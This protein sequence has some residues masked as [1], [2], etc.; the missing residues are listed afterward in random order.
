M[1][2]SDRLFLSVKSVLTAGLPTVLCVTAITVATFTAGTIFHVSQAANRFVS[3]QLSR[4]GIG[5]VTLYSPE[6]IRDPDGA[7][8]CLAALDGADGIMPFS[9][10]SGVL[11]GRE[12][13]QN[14]VFMG[15][16]ADVTAVYQLEMLHGRG[17]TP[18]EL[19]AGEPV[20]LVD[21]QLAQTLYKRSN[22]LG[23]QLR[24]GADSGYIAATVIGV[25]RSQ[26]QGLESAFGIAIPEII[27]LPLNALDDFAGSIVLDKIAVTC[28]DGVDQD[29]FGEQAARELTRLTGARFKY[30]NISGYY[31]LITDV[32]A[33]TGRAILGI[34][35]VA[36]LVGGLGL[37]IAML[38]AVDRRRHTIGIYMALG[39][40]AGTVVGLFILEALELCLIGGTAGSLLSLAAMNLLQQML[41][42][43]VR[44]DVI[45]R[46]M[47]WSGISGVFFGILPAVRAARMDPIQAL[48]D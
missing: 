17:F 48:T 19:A 39:A 34:G 2:L 12:S 21:D 9:V 40:P 20:I 44:R 5:G 47:F 18:S 38:S 4:I 13:R 14:A 10:T 6:P 26:K 29:A 23:K 43:E 22:I 36:V 1:R 16:N 31:G 45:L 7:A 8:A 32:T 24:L 27:Y 11:R 46:V 15:V 25:Y 37:M 35:L 41:P 28:L 42:I 33:L 3:D 30:E